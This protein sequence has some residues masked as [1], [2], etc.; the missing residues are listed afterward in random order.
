MGI[1]PCER[2]WKEVLIEPGAS[3]KLRSP[4]TKAVAGFDSLNPG[5]PNI[6]TPNKT[7][8]KKPVQPWL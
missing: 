7:F 6:K 4:E 1:P 8:S 5:N 2:R 3:F